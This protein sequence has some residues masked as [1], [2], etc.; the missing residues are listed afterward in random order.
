MQVLTL[1]SGF[2]AVAIA[3]IAAVGFMSTGCAPAT[4]MAMVPMTKSHVSPITMKEFGKT[5]D[6]QAVQQYTLNAGNGASVSLITY[7]ATVTNLYVPDKTGMVSDVILGFDNIEQYQT[8]SPYFGAVV[9]R[10]GNRIAKGQ[11]KIEDHTYAVP[12]NNGPNHLHGGFKGYDKRVWKAD[13][14]ML[15]DGP[16]V[17]FTLVDPDGCEG[18]PGTVNVTVIYSLTGGKGDDGAYNGLKIQYYATTTQGTPINLTNHTYFNLKDAGA[19]SIAGHWMRVFGDHYTPV[20]STLIPTGEI[21]PV[22]GTPIDFTKAKPIGRDM[23]AMGG[24]PAGY[25]HNIALTNQDGSFAKAVQVYEPD[26]GRLMDVWTTEPGV[27]FYSGNFLDGSFAG[28]DGIVYKQHNALV[29][30]CQHYPDSV[31]QPKF[32]AGGCAQTWRSLSAGY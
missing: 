15:A 2:K 3:A 27:Q 23:I 14:A 22:A 9:G 5:Y 20:D 32:P 6:G 11:F 19:T 28:K 10:V 17:K 8:Q 7:G 29:L 18:Y 12:V 26:T 31:N 25:D 16:S 30:E 24:D 21:A 13:A 4:E 1:R